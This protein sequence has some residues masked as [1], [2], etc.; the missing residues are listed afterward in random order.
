MPGSFEKDKSTISQGNS[1]VEV[2]P[3]SINLIS[4]NV[5]QN[6]EP[7]IGAVGP[8]GLKGD[9]GDTGA[10]GAT[11]ATGPAG[12]SPH[13]G[14]VTVATVTANT[15]GTIDVTISDQ[16]PIDQI[17]CFTR[18]GN[19][20]YVQMNGNNGSTYTIVYQFTGTQTNRIIS[21]MYFL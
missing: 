14:S 7:I 6:G 20:G 13:F 3:D 19:P 10:T 1:V 21:W 8:Q 9:K 18:G 17:I 15:M 16:P 12:A 5:L 4:E 11:G 2:Q